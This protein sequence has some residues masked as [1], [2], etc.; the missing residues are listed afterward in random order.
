MERQI[1]LENKAWQEGLALMMEKLAERCVPKNE[2]VDVR[3]ALHRITGSIVRARRSSPHFAASAMDGYAI[4]AKDTHGIS[5]REPRWLELGNQA[6]QVDTGDPVPEGMDAV[7]MLEDV[8]ELGER[9][10]LIQAPVVPWNHVRP[11]GEDIVEGEVL[12]PI[13]HRIRPQDQGALLA[14]G[15]LD[16]EVRCKPRVGILPTGDEICP[17]EAV[18]QVGEIVDSNS[19]VLA[20]LVEEWGGSATIWPITPDQPEKLENA[21][22]EMAA[23]QDILVIIAGSSQ[24][25]DDYTSHMVQKHGTLYLHGVAIKPGKPVVLGEIQGKPTFGIPGY[26]VSTYLTAHLFLE[27]WVYHLQ[28]LS[29]GLP[30]RLDAVISKKVFSSLG[31]EEFVRVKVGKVGERWVAAPLS[32]G[33]GVTMSLVRADGMIRVPRLQEGFHEGETVPVDLLR[34]VSELEETLVCIGSHDLTLDVL[35]SHMKSRDGRGALASAHVGSLAGILSLR[36]G[37]A[38]FAGIHLLDPETGEYNRSYLQR[39]LPGREV[40]LMNLV[41]R[42]QVLIVP[43]GNPLNLK[44]LEDLA[45]PGVRFINR[46]GGSGTR[47]LLDYL[48]QKQGLSK[49]QI[50]GYEREEFTHLAVA[51]AVASGAAD[52]GLGI[53]S[54]AEALGLDY[55]LVGEERYDLAIPREF[56]EEPRM[57]AMIEV[58]QSR[59]F[60]EDVLALGGY[61]VRDTGVFYG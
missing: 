35:S 43:K 59:A 27:P 44:T 14:A 50:L 30:A 54:A 2:F 3:S 33:A 20:S 61:D 1:Y 53:Q 19:T 51:V 10:I 16:V 28:G 6:I 23:S 12:L 11:V 8:L 9:G 32:R 7:V 48:L 26:P 22:L 37:E 36:K 5:E 25:R 13:H 34:P 29:K 49:E 38:H 4:R 24:G 40:A 15:I 45:K 41:Y 31:S 52:V 58:I 60:Q 55:V 39:F 56:L 47:V 46:Q 18:L 17:P 42:T 57:K 21:I